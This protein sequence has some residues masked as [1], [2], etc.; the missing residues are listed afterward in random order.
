MDVNAKRDDETL[1]A[2]RAAYKAHGTWR[3]TADALNAN[4]RAPGFHPSWLCLVANGT[5]PPT[6]RLARALGVVTEH[7][8]DRVRFGAWMTRGQRDAL[9]EQIEGTGRGRADWLRE[10]MANSVA[11]E[12]LADMSQAYPLDVFP[13]PD[14]KLAAKLLRD[15]GVTL[16]SVSAGIMRRAWELVE[17]LCRAGADGAEE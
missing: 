8:D 5:R 13:E 10:A 12:K 15:G 14:W 11:M 4:R 1:N 6:R 16:D 9:V 3:R 7:E 2:L 17:N